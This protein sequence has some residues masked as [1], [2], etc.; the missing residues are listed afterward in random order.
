MKVLI[1]FLFVNIYLVSFSQ[2]GSALIKCLDKD[3]QYGLNDLLV[4][5]CQDTICLDGKTQNGGIVLLRNQRIGENVLKITDLKRARTLTGSIFIQANQLA[6]ATLYIDS[7]FTSLYASEVG[8]NVQLD[9]NGNSAANIN[10]ANQNLLIYNPLVSRTASSIQELQ[11][12]TIVSYSRP[13]LNFYGNMNSQSITR[14]DITRLPVRSVNGV[15]STVGGVQSPISSEEINIRGARAGSDA[16]YLDGIRIRNASAIPKSHIGQVTVYTGGIPANYGDLT[17]GVISVES[18]N[19]YSLSQSHY[20]RRNE[21]YTPASIP[22]YTPVNPIQTHDHFLPIYENDF[23]SPLENPHS[24]F[25]L[26][27]DRASWSFIKRQFSMG[28]QISHDAVKLEEM[29]NSFQ[30][31]DVEVPND[32]LLHVEIERNNCSWNSA[33]ELVTIHLKGKDLPLDSKRIRHNLVFLIDVSGSM[34]SADRLPLLLQGLKQFVRTL[35]KEDRVAIVTYAGT[36]GVALE[37]TNCSQLQKI[38]DALDRLSSGGSTNGI[39]GV[40]EAYRLAELHFDP[41]LNNRIILATDGD[42]NVGISATNELEKYIE[43]KRGQGIYLTALGFGMGNYKNSILETLADK[44][45][46]NHFYIQNIYDMKKVLTEDIGNLINLARDVKLNVEFNPHLVKSY[47]LIGYENRLLKPKDF[48]DDTKDGGEIGYGHRVTAVYEIERG[49]AENSKNHFVVNQGLD[50]EKELAFVRLRY[51]PLDNSVSLEKQYEL[52]ISQA[53]VPNQ[54]L[55]IVI[56]LGLHLRDS[57][58]KGSASAAALQQLIL[59]FSPKNEDE[60]ELKRIVQS[61]ETRQSTHQ[62]KK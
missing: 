40:Q 52:P 6:Q 53:V 21:E 60:F 34:S 26:D 1:L 13:L 42:F 57:A 43:D 33:H 50:S 56:S 44:G 14:E 46:G 54:L 18:V 8:N 3:N 51:K 11:C 59:E 37:P 32:Q 9:P 20:A 27:V 22:V 17:G 23:L 15:A 29:I 39:G 47:R 10:S 4:E 61:I 25:G 38:E 58:F 19:H 24:T 31:K 12:V 41:T 36:T 7:S 48:E 5:F 30:Q 35:D 16:Y 62:D 45:D 55:N 28:G 49:I 2:S